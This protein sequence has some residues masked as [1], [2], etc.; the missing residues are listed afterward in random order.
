M[1]Q[2]EHAEQ[3][4]HVEPGL[5]RGGWRVL[6]RFVQQAGLWRAKSYLDVYMMVYEHQYE[7]VLYPGGMTSRGYKASVI[8]VQFSS[9]AARQASEQL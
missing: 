6:Q 2:A 5:M 4:I 3:V 1:E 8:H 7:A 9:R